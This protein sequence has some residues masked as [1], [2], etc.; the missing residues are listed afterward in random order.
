M[1]YA[2]CEFDIYTLN[3]KYHRR[4]KPTEVHSYDHN[5]HTKVVH[6]NITKVFLQYTRCTKWLPVRWFKVIASSS[7]R[8]VSTPFVASFSIDKKIRPCHLK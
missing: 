5:D 1:L 7:T 6:N 3:F 8:V 4:L 2:F